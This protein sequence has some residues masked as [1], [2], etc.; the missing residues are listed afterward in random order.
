MPIRMSTLAG[1]H[2]LDD[3]LLLLRGAEARDHLDVDGELREA[4]L[5]GF[6]VLEAEHGG[7]REHGHLLAVLHGLE[8]GAHG[9]FGFAVAHVAAQQAVHR[10]RRFHVVLDGADGRGLIVGL[11]V[12]ESVFKLA[13][14]LVVF[15]EGRALRGVALGVELEQLA[16]HVAAW[17]SARAPWFWSTAASRAC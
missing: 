16:G 14:E 8:G 17:P 1:G 2:A 6:E 5:E 4:L 10:R 11:A 9:H 15:G 13:L 12:V 7:G 3:L